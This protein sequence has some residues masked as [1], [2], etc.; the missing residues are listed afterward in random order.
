MPEL[1]SL[2]DTEFRFLT[3][4][5]EQCRYIVIHNYMKWVVA[6]E[7]EHVFVTKNQI[8]RIPHFSK[9]GPHMFSMT[10]VVW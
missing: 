6:V 2:R 8:P 1:E 3:L 4:T 9:A 10:T 5:I 7:S